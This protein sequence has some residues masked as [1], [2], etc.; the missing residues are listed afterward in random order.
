MSVIRAS[1]PKF[2]VEQLNSIAGGTP[3]PDVEEALGQWK[4]EYGEDAPPLFHRRAQAMCGAWETFAQS[5]TQEALEAFWKAQDSCESMV[6]GGLAG[7]ALGL[8]PKEALTSIRPPMSEK[9]R[10]GLK[11]LE[12]RERDL[13]I[14]FN[15]R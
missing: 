14:Q 13:I 3:P 12:A 4:E 8:T 5:R 10:R 2:S 9:V 7:S 1:F 6:E 11:E 15:L